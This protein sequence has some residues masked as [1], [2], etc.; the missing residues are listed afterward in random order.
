MGNVMLN[1]TTGI[2]YVQSRMHALQRDFK[3]V[4]TVLIF[5]QILQPLY[6]N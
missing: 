2:S 5:K 3:N 1:V 4:Q 6:K